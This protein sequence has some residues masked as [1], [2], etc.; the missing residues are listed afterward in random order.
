[1]L[2]SEWLISQRNRHDIVGEL[3]QQLAKLEWPKTNELLVL[4]VRLTLVKGSPLAHRALERA[5]EEWEASRHLPPINVWR[6]PASL[7]VN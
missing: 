4:K 5:W 1:M 6:P 3:G 7:V 2:F